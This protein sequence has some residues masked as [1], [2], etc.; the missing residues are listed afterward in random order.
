LSRFTESLAVVG[1]QRDRLV[2]ALLRRGR[3]ERLAVGRV[4]VAMGRIDANDPLH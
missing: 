1:V 3:G 4:G 2:E